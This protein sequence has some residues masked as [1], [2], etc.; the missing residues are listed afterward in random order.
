MS[1]RAIDSYQMT[2]RITR[3]LRAQMASFERRDVSWSQV[4]AEAFRS[5]LNEL[6][7]SKTLEQRVA[8]IE[9]RLGIEQ[10]NHADHR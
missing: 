2:V 1:S 10:E 3:E 6:R 4:A 8:H 7:G 9:K 5:K